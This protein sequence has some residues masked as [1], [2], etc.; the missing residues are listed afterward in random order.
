MNVSIVQTTSLSDLHQLLGASYWAS[1]NTS[2]CPAAA[3]HRAQTE[4]LLALINEAR[5][6][7]LAPTVDTRAF[8]R[9]LVKYFEAKLLTQVPY[10]AKLRYPTDWCDKELCKEVVEKWVNGDYGIGGNTC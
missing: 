2:Y 6:I 3:Y 5:P 4:K 7:L 1:E 10:I 8:R 9:L